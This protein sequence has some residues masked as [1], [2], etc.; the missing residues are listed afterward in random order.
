[1]ALVSGSVGGQR[2]DG[3][4]EMGRDERVLALWVRELRDGERGRIEKVKRGGEA[5]KESG[6]R[7]EKKV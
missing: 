2:W 7:H 3:L 6:V 4:C 1:M 5:N